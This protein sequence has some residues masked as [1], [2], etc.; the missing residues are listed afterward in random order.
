MSPQFE[1]RTKPVD[2]QGRTS[3]RRSRSAIGRSPLH[4]TVDLARLSRDRPRPPTIVVRNE[5]GRTSGFSRAHEN[6]L[7]I[8]GLRAPAARCA[9]YC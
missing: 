6:A 9:L 3:E 5:F 2:N 1:V 7:Q 8:F 4:Q